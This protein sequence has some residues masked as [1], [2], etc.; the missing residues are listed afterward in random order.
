M[1]QPPR[2]PDL[3][4]AATTLLIFDPVFYLQTYEI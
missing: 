2:P 1:F 4:F 3:T